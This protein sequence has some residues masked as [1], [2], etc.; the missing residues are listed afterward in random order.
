MLGVADWGML[1]FLVVAGYGLGCLNTG[2]Y[3]VRWRT[4]QDIRTLGSG[5]AGARNTGRILGRWGFVAAL[6][7]DVLKGLL[8]V[9]AARLVGLPEWAWL[10]VLFAAL[11]GHIWPWQ[12]QGRGGKGAA[13]AL[14][15]VLAITP[16]AGAFALV[17]VAVLRGTT[18]RTV[19]SGVPAA[20]SIP[21]MAWLTGLSPTLVIGLVLLLGLMVYTHRDNL[22]RVLRGNE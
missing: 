11:A 21:L 17:L 1:L 3:L 19:L 4:G 16:L 12:L 5:N 18:K 20:V 10:G 8:P 22:R 7:G 9:A 13:T 2:Y 15:G 6:L 14:G